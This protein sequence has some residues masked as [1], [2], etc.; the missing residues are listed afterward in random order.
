MLEVE[1]EEE[2]NNGGGVGECV[3][4]GWRRWG[5]V[6]GK[7]EEQEWR[8]YKKKGLFQGNHA[9]GEIKTGCILSMLPSGHRNLG[10]GENQDKQRSDS[11]TGSGANIKYLRCERGLKSIFKPDP[12]GRKRQASPTLHQKQDL[13]CLDEIKM[14]CIQL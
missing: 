9:G 14:I 6:R 7:R 11:L 12:K 10:E 13:L 8:R 1:V 4:E 2:L 5:V 3:P